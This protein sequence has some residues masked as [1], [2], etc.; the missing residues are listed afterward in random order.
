[1][2]DT[3]VQSGSSLSYNQSVVNIGP[4]AT[5]AITLTEY[6]PA[7]TTVSF[8]AVPAGWSCGTTVSNTFTC[9]TTPALGQAGSLT[10][11]NVV[12]GATTPLASN[13]SVSFGM[14]LSGTGVT[15]TVCEWDGATTNYESNPLDNLAAASTTVRPAADADVQVSAVGVPATGSS[16][17]PGNNV[18]ESFTISNNGPA[19]VTYASS[20]T[21]ALN[22]SGTN[23]AA[24]DW[25]TNATFYS[26]APPSNWTC[27]TPAVGAAGA[28]SCYLNS[29]S[30]APG[31][32]VSIPV[33][34]KVNST[35]LSGTNLT[36]SGTVATTYTDPVSAN[37][38]S[39]AQNTISGV[40]DLAWTT[41]TATAQQTPGNNASY[42][43]ILINNGPSDSTNVTVTDTLP[44]N[45]TFVSM[46]TPAGWS[47]TDPA[48]GSAGTITCTIADLAQGAI[49]T[50]NPVFKI[51]ASTTTTPIINTI[52]ASSSTT[53]DPNLAN[54]SAT[55]TTNVSLAGNVDLAVTNTPSATSLSA[56]NN[57]TYTQV[58]TNYG[59]ASTPAAAGSQTIT[60]T[61]P[62]NTTFVSF[63]PTTG[64]TCSPT[65]TVGATG[66]FS[67][68]NT[69]GATMPSGSAATFT[70]VV[71]VNPG[72]PDGTVIND[73]TMVSTTATDPNLANNVATATVHVADAN[74]A[75][76]GIS[77]VG[78]TTVLAGNNATYTITVTNNTTGVNATNVTVTD[79]I[80]GNAIDGVSQTQLT[81]VSATPSV[82]SCSQ[83]SGTV[84][85]DLGTLAP[86]AANAAT[87]TLVASTAV[88]T[89][90][91]NPASVIAD[92]QT[93]PSTSSVQTVVSAPTDVRLRSFVAGYVGDDV[94]LE[95]KTGG[96]LRNLGFN[97]YREVNGTRVRLN[98]SLIAGSALRM[99]GA[100]EQHTAS[101]YS[102]IDRAPQSGAVYWIEDV[103]VHGART[104][105]GAVAP[106]SNAGLTGLP[107]ARTLS[108]IRTPAVAAVSGG[109]SSGSQLQSFAKLSSTAAQQAV[110]N[111]LAS[112]PATK[113]AVDHEGWYSI[114]LSSI[115]ATPSGKYYHLYAEGVEQP[116][117]ITG[118]TATSAGI[119]EFYGT[120]IDTPYTGMRIYWLVANNS[121]SIEIGQAAA[122][123]NGG[124]TPLSF[125]YT[126]QLKQR[127]TY[128][129]TLM[130]SGNHFFGDAVTTDPVSET[131][132][133][134][135]LAKDAP[136][137]VITVV[138]QGAI[139]QTAH[140]VC[141]A[142]NGVGVGV[143]N[144]YGM[145]QGTLQV[146]L[147]P[148]VLKEGTNTVMLNALNGENDVSLL[149]HIDL[150]YGHT[151]TA[152]SDALKFT[153]IPGE[154]VIVSGF[155]QQPL[156]LVDISNP[157]M[158]IEIA[159]HAVSQ[160]SGYALDFAVPPTS[161]GIHTFMAVAADTTSAPQEIT[162]TA[163]S[164]WNA[165]QSGSDVVMIS[166]PTF[167]PALK[168]LVTLHGNQGHSVAVVPIGDIY[169]EFNY[170][171]KDPLAIQ[172]FLKTAIS[173]W[174]NK[175]RYLLLVGN[176]S[177]DPR[178]YLGMGNF[179][180]VPT[181]I[182]PTTELMTASDDWF[183][184]FNNNGLAQIPT[185]R[186]PV[187]TAAQA[188]LVVN[189]IVG[190]ES[191]SASFSNNMLF[192]AD[193]DDTESFTQSTKS[194][195][196]S[197]PS[198][199]IPIDV[200]DSVEGSAAP[201]EI[202][203]D[204]NSGPVMVNYFGHG[205]EAQWSNSN[206]FDNN[207]AAA[208]TN[209]N[210]LPVFL[211]MTCLNGFFD[212]VYQQSLAT[213]V[214]ES[215]NGGGVA[216]FASSGLLDPAPQV[217]LDRQLLQSLAANPSMPL[218][219][220]IAGAKASITD[221]DTRRTYI[222]FGD[223]L[224]QVR[225]PK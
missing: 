172:E 197:L 122:H 182:V 109:V 59:A 4:S 185:G 190:Y 58:F 147:P 176:A 9:S 24:N 170:G 191:N 113:I 202:V 100:L 126:V 193:A 99:R 91:I 84:T 136:A 208:L 108:Q 26:I 216:V 165:A 80:P 134:T 52:G 41:S 46:T 183:S 205:S 17:Y 65:L 173:Q 78:S 137:P 106:Q 50:F 203:N 201:Q 135:N 206:L 220:A 13:A 64:L 195:Q 63:G 22:I 47:C 223:P 89:T 168:P 1:M 39:E 8:S 45:T 143:I 90:Y 215:A 15:G 2:S 104:L 120:A 214:L 219:D 111:Q 35:T 175:P 160:G 14:T 141:L 124:E 179:D 192:V 177:V 132:T 20:S 194:V 67:C 198:S 53:T 103:D 128:F 204:I 188:S 213:A 138:L 129:A 55:Q 72:T 21:F 75:N 186:L 159:K 49:A 5:G 96:E 148:N 200:L 140:E 123:V 187:V 6:V 56:G 209:G 31:A 145:D 164:S 101:G 23:S 130:T 3:A 181:A 107:Q 86:G 68:S 151:Y 157:A 180:F 32:S 154:H 158:P 210:Q 153:A 57:I 88:P 189:K 98:S 167:A 12:S 95:W 94:V 69:A 11:T 171:E 163:G 110:Q 150:Q 48:V 117:R 76:V 144:F 60:E 222:L 71:Q 40:A 62:P 115:T 218:G 152:E 105:H 87:I 133:V 85:C 10:C 73:T 102:F 142:V 121:P 196:V 28:I 81:Y 221:L 116:I 112:G 30:M 82:G 44:A 7:N 19:T 74:S 70:L 184:D 97:V 146:Q 174:Q 149:D 18:V 199:L 114:N 36:A 118:Q 38:S 66:T 169:D 33:T 131:L 37:N 92:Q 25:I 119:L 207:A 43:L 93:T 16:L 161:S 217:E 225:L 155:S 61:I 27:S 178:D 125:P 139:D 79:V 42:N 212:D 51:S 77:M 34:L 54:N 224:L 29:G 211:M 127:T 83:A 162:Y 166:D 156:R